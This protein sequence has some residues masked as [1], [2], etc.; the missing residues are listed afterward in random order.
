[1][2]L[3]RWKL[4]IFLTALNCLFFLN[5]CVDVELGLTVNRDGSGKGEWTIAATD[6]MY[7][8]M[9]DEL[10]REVGEDPTATITERYEDGRKIVNIK[11]SF[12]NVDELS[13]FGSP[14]A[15]THR[16]DNRRHRVEIEIKENMP[17][18]LSLAMPGKILESNGNFS[19]STVSW[20]TTAIGHIY[21]A[22]SEE[23]AGGIPLAF[24]IASLAVIGGILFWRLQKSRVS[25]GAMASMAASSREAKGKFCT[26]CGSP[27]A[28]GER[29]CSQ[30]GSKVGH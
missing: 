19:G 21:W 17:M 1:M 24:V 20:G 29:F 25:S 22:E 7:N 15:V 13:G 12:Q 23:A 10:I 11:G 16:R 27:L 3:K 6:A 2:L 5:G 26:S 8:D 14:V 9:I 28:P 18:K 30:C 4:I